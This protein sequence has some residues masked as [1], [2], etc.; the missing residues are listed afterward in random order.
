MCNKALLIG[1]GFSDFQ[2]IQE[3]L[4]TSEMS[5]FVFKFFEMI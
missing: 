1:I 3:V 4:F 2:S 5:Y